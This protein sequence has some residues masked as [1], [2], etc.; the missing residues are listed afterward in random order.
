M[1]RKL[2]EIGDLNLDI[3]YS[4]RAMARIMGTNHQRAKRLLAKAGIIPIHGK[5]WLVDIRDNAPRVYQ[6]IIT[7][8]HLKEKGQKLFTPTLDPDDDV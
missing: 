2:A 8:F 5:I 1:A 4:L 6:S 7:L 3:C